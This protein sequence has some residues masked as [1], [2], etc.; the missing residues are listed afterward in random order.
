MSDSRLSFREI[1]LTY[2]GA[3][4]SV[5]ALSGFDLEVGAGESVALIGPSG[6]GKTS[7]LLMAAGLLKPTSGQVLVNAAAIDAPRFK[8]ALIL[9]D[10]GLLP[11]KNV[12]ENAS[13][14]L[15]LRKIPRAERF[16]RTQDA[17]A[18][19]DLTDFAQAWPDELSGG[20]RQRLALARA[21][22]LEADLFLMDEPLSALDAL[23]RER[24]QDLLLD[25]WHRRGHSQL[26]VTHSIE[27]AAYLGQRIVIMTPRPG[28]IAE[29]ISNA[30]MGEIGYRKTAAF[31]DCCEQI[32]RALHA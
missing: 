11:W 26:V 1:S 19:V 9:Q 21:L 12:F 7:A 32:R 14:G 2:R 3:S 16:V 27:E 20:M 15:R 28:R 31:Q 22:T 30:E 13:L 25:L 5:Q 18:E 24:L 23:L 17:L 10:F 4:A 6:S 29:V 8:T